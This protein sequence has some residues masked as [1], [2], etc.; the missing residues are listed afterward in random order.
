MRH[1]K[2]LHR[3]SLTFSVSLTVAV[4]SAQPLEQRTHHFGAAE[5]L[6]A[7]P[8]VLMVPFQSADLQDSG[9]R[10][11]WKL[12]LGNGPAGANLAAT[13]DETPTFP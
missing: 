10:K 12:S 7:G 1:H 8:D 9:D 5:A 6:E 13:V 4:V 2:K 11:P 3:R